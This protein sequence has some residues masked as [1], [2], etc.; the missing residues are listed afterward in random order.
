[1]AKIRAKNTKPEI[2]VRKA[3]HS[4]GF[5]FRIHRKDLPGNPD[6][7][8]PRLRKI[9]LVHGCFWHRHAG[10]KYTYTPKSNIDFWT[11]KFSN[12]IERDNKVAQQLK[13]LGWEIMIIWD[14][15]VSKTNEL[16]KNI[17]SFLKKPSN[18]SDPGFDVIDRPE[19]LL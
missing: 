15:E 8:F 18:S 16:K 14:C 6:I 2:E 4:L 1:M 7:V 19:L 3:A 11:K 9:I 5:R 13:N 10:C 17:D 12:N